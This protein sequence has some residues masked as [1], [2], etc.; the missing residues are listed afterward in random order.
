MR[1]F[2]KPFANCDLI[3]YWIMACVSSK[4][5][6]WNYSCYFW[7]QGKILNEDPFISITQSFKG[8]CFN[9]VSNWITVYACTVRWLKR[10]YLLWLELI[11]PAHHHLA[12]IRFLPVPNVCKAAR[13]AQFTLWVINAVIEI[14]EIMSL[15]REQYF[16]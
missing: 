4:L 5:K 11:K 9:T 2:L 8:L 10:Q 7:W 6:I 14:E 1:L 3:L 15:L 13:G 12:F 16:N